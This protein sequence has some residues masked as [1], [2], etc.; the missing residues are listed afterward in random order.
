MFTDQIKN[1]IDLTCD[2]SEGID[3]FLYGESGD[4]NKLKCYLQICDFAVTY[5]SSFCR[6][7]ML[8]ISEYTGLYPVTKDRF[9]AYIDKDD[10]LGAITNLPIAVGGVQDIILKFI[11]T[12]D[13]REL[14]S[15]TY[16]GTA[17]D[18]F[19]MDPDESSFMEVSFVKKIHLK[20]TASLFEPT[21]KETNMSKLFSY[22]ALEFDSSLIYPGY[23]I[24][25]KMNTVF[26]N[27]DLKFDIMG[28][29]IF[30]AKKS[31]YSTTIIYSTSANKMKTAFIELVSDGVG[32]PELTFDNRETAIELTNKLG[33]TGIHFG[34]L[35]YHV[36]KVVEG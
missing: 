11:F 36:E 31:I 12:Y 6:H 30:N 15:I 7:Y 3:S 20:Y 27:S 5:D 4:S 21:A 17:M 28:S 24:P 14:G 33:L 34:N 32:Y 29:V 19:K 13:S 23:H 16:G 26:S 25:E 2:K 1:M 9:Q 35:R 18:V 8:D 10:L 22:P